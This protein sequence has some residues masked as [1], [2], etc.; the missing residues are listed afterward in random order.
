MKKLQLWPS[1]T[2]PLVPLCRN[3]IAAT[4]LLLMLALPTLGGTKT[5]SYQPKIIAGVVKAD[6]WTMNNNREGIYELNVQGSGTLTQL[7]DGQDK[8]LAPLGGAV[9]Y[10]GKMHGIHF[11]QSDDPL[12]ESGITYS[13][14]NVAYNMD[15]W[16]QT[17]KKWLSE[18]YANLISS[19]GL[20]T[21][22]LTGQHYGIFY[23][24]GLNFEVLGL[25]LAT[26][27][28]DNTDSQGAPRRE[29][30]DN[31]DTHFAAITFDTTGTLYGVGTDGFLYTIDPVTAEVTLVGDL[32]ISNISSYP[33][34]MTCDPK[35]GKI[36]WSVV[37][38]ESAR[39][40]SYLY[41]INTRSGTPQATRLMAV[42]DN[43]F[44][45]NMHIA[46]PQAAD[47]APA[48]AEDLIVTT[49]GESTTATVAFTSPTA[50]YD[51][52]TLSG[53]LNYTVKANGN[54]VK[55]GTCQPGQAVSISATLPLGDVIVSVTVSNAAGN[56]PAAET[57][58]YVGPATPGAPLNVTFLYDYDTHTSHVSWTAPAQGTNGSTLQ[59]ANLTYNVYRMEDGVKVASAMSGTTFS[60]PFSPSTLASYYYKVEAI[61]KN[62][63]TGESAESNRAV[64]GPPLNVPFS[65][66]FSS[67]QDFNMMT[68]VDA[69]SDGDTWKWS[70]SLSGNGTAEFYSSKKN[71]ADDWLLTPPVMLNG[72]E[73]YILSFEANTGT[74]GSYDIIEVAF[75]KGNNIDNYSTLMDETLIVTPYCE[76]PYVVNGIRPAETGVYFFGIHCTTPSGDGWLK[77]DNL[78]LTRDVSTPTALQ[79][80]SPE[81]RPS[82][83]GTKG[84]I[85]VANAQQQAVLVF[86]TDGTQIDAFTGEDYMLRTLSPGLYVVKIGN[87][88][89]KVMVR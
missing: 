8:L 62:Q 89:Y 63:I 22:P 53:T 55:S 17:G 77:V 34:S 16:Q 25:R 69:N 71:D 75:G 13:I 44:L 52:G 80:V 84:A 4:L 2:F 18:A 65:Q 56:S 57:Q 42:P 72:G 81:L 70:K 3:T 30:V 78:S 40:K 14:C 48:A 64:A 10:G 46:P 36:Y 41:E 9:Y 20:T 86:A 67:Q 26:I 60:E 68:V 1:A 6:S 21:D 11:V 29:I 76:E 79:P 51:G 83:V 43:A 12:N 28:F 15:N 32:G 82:V 35:T 54:T 49:E 59:P 74:W 19:C 5:D 50:T 87:R 39:L 45:V 47:G 85:A 38:S 88:A 61:H 31:I 66:T 58:I 7:N 37:L 23:N 33:S 73:R 27:D 24:F